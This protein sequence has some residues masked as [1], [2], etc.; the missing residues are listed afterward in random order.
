MIQVAYAIGVAQPVSIYVKT[1]GTGVI[2]DE[3]ISAILSKEVDMTPRGII[4]RLDL[5]RPIYKKTSSYGHFGRTE[6]DFTWER[7]D[8]VP[9]LKKA[10][11]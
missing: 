4:S 10:A 3:Q 2:P 11:K 8:L 7:L 9:M 1:F 5:L 6:K